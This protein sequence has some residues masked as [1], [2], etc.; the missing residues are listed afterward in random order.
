MAQATLPPRALL[1]AACLVA[2]AGCGSKPE[3]TPPP[4]PPPQP[5]KPSIQV[6]DIPDFQV[7]ILLNDK[8]LANYDR[9]RGGDYDFETK[10]AIKVDALPDVKTLKAQGLHPDGWKDDVADIEKTSDSTIWV[11][12]KKPAETFK[13]KI[14]LQVDN[15]GQEATEIFVGEMPRTIKAGEKGILSYPE[16]SAE[17]HAAVRIRGQEVGTLWPLTE[18]D[19]PEAQAKPQENRQKYFVDVT[20][21]R[22]YRY[23][24]VYYS[25]EGIS[26]QT[27]EALNIK[28]VSGELNA[29]FVHRVP[30]SFWYL[31]EPAPKEI[32]VKPNLS[33]LFELRTEIVER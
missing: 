27:A 1:L 5:R 13:S 2:V 17:K 23:R 20:G 14:A 29:K 12:F 7:R 30:F 33:Q 16:P 18:L 31:L 25:S 28:P 24:E 11:T 19:K 21:K 22:S 6:G 10:A 32:A 9:H 26:D 15:R 4:T 3:P 8:E